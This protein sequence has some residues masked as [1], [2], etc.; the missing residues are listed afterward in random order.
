M[1][2][3]HLPTAVWDFIIL[4]A[5]AK[6]SQLQMDSVG[7]AIWLC[8]VL[9]IAKEAEKNRSKPSQI[10]HLKLMGSFDLNLL[11]VNSILQRREKLELPYLTRSFNSRKETPK[12]L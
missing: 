6:Y 11:L 7:P 3:R 1:E 5:G 4:S 8:K 12:C 9:H 10:G 2:E